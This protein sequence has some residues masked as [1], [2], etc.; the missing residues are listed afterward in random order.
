[1][2]GID[3]LAPLRLETRFL[4]PDAAHATWRLRLRV[5]PDEFS[6]RRT[7]PPPTPEPLFDFFDSGLT[8]AEVALLLADGP[9]PIPDAKGT[10]RMLLDLAAGGEVVRVPLGQ[11]ALW[12]RA[13]TAALSEPDRTEAALA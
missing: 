12:R 10:E 4:P 3:V 7:P 1:M 8:T 11:D 9:D 6:M 13:A 5:Y 2:P